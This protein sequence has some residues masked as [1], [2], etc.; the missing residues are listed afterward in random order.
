MVVFQGGGFSFRFAKWLGTCSNLL[1]LKM[2]FVV[3][4]S[5]VECSGVRGSNT[6]AVF[7]TTCKLPDWFSKLWSRGPK[8]T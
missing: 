5:M 6:R 3:L 8:C 7:S 1:V 2:K 4:G